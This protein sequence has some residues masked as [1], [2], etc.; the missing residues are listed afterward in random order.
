M[1]KDTKI[2]VSHA[3]EDKDDFAREF[4]EKLK[5][6]CQVWYDEYSIPFGG[7]IFGSISAGLR[8]CDFGVVIFSEVFFT[9]KWTQDELAG[10]V[11]REGAGL[12]RIIP[13]WKGVTVE[14]VKAF[15][16]IFV[17]RRGIDAGKGIDNAIACVVEAIGTINSSVGFTTTRG[18]REAPEDGVARLAE[19]YEKMLAAKAMNQATH[20]PKAIREAQTAMLGSVAER[21]EKVALS[22]PV[23]KLTWESGEFRCLPNDIVWLNVTFANRDILRMEATRPNYP[24]DT[25]RLDLNLFR[26]K[27]DESGAYTYP[28]HLENYRFSPE[29]TSE[30]E[31]KW[32]TEAKEIHASDEISNLFLNCLRN[33]LERLIKPL[34]E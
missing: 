26:P 3:T 4:A 28:D 1:K 19:K 33:H 32:K 29:L 15:S 9:K 22:N 23:L 25:T 24:G 5:S 20:A 13:I 18:D 10:L 8:D 2:F 16:P 27:R 30:G 31:V 7:S 21:I 6:H 34:L 12:H 17:D 11:A 14:Q